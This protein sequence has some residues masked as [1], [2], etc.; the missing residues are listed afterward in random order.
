MVESF[1]G[2]AA[3]IQREFG[4]TYQPETVRSWKHRYG[5]PT[6]TINGRDAIS[7]EALRT[8]LASRRITRA[9]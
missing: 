1:K 2:M 3:F 7:P 8:W 6:E 4:R 9:A 5:L